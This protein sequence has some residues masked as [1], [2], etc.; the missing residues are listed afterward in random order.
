MDNLTFQVKC[1]QFKVKCR[2]FIFLTGEFIPGSM[3]ALQTCNGVR[4]K[5]RPWSSILKLVCKQYS[6]V[7]SILGL[8]YLNQYVDNITNLIYS[9]IF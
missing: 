4:L 1:E 2:Q 8:V 5:G 6:I 3:A 9:S 7:Y